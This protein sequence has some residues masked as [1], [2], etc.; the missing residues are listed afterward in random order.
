MSGR[1][2]AVVEHSLLR[3]GVCVAAQGCLAPPP[4]SSQDRAP[5]PKRGDPGETR[6][7]QARGGPGRARQEKKARAAAIRRQPRKSPRLTLA[8]PSTAPTTASAR[9][10]THG[11]R[12]LHYRAGVGVRPG[13]P[14]TRGSQTRATGREKKTHS[15]ILSISPYLGLDAGVLGRQVELFLPVLAAR[16]G[17]GRGGQGGGGGRRGA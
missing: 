2:G 1:G 16:G 7:G 17:C 13:A 6:V 15:L 8:L 4:P 9:A 14:R 10:R 12:R 5:F 3:F 11:M